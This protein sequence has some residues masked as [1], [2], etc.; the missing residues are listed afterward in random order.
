[1]TSRNTGF[2]GSEVSYIHVDHDLVGSL[3][4]KRQ[5]AAELTT[6]PRQAVQWHSVN[7]RNILLRRAVHRDASGRRG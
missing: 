7:D 4:L 5:I 1:M 6:S 2:R 3:C